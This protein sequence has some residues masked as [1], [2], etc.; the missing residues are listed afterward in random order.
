MAAISSRSEPAMTPT[1][2]SAALPAP[3]FAPTFAAATASA[4]ACRSGAPASAGI[5]GASTLDAPDLAGA[6]VPRLASALRTRSFDLAPAPSELVA[7]PWFP[8]EV[9]T[10][11]SCRRAAG[12]IARR[13]EHAY[14]LLRQALGVAPALRLRVLDRAAWAAHSATAEFGVM[15][16]D[17]EGALVIGT[18]PAIAWAAV[19]RW[20]ARHLDA[21]SLATLVRVHGVDTRTGGPALDE[22]AEALVAHELAHLVCAQNAVAFPRAW[23]GEAFAN[24]AMVAT[25]AETDPLGLRRL[26]SLAEAAA[27]LTQFTPTLAE[28]EAS[29]GAM[30]VVPSVLAQLALTRAVYATYAKAQV[31]PLAR[32][33]RVFGGHDRQDGDGREPDAD[34][35]LGRLLAQHVH[36]TVADIPGHFPAAAYRAAA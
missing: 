19:S 32:L 23:L 3:A 4:S 10:P 6:P 25:L 7:L 33:F 22:V 15:H 12:R 21:R 31:A 36:D 17:A 16:V 27:T 11:A 20:L 13:A 9:R 34:F 24:Y 28:F 29:F 2:R 14:W 5:S 1:L 30:P 26:G 18:E 8:F 35:E